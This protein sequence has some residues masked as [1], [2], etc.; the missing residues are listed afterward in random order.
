MVIK[1][2]G[3]RIKTL[4]EDK[5][6]SQQEMANILSITRSAYSNYENSLREVPL[7]VLSQIADFHQTSVDFL[8]GRTNDPTPY[9]PKEHSED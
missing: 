8:I 1:L 4:R 7:A 2:N 5:D 6:L 3:K 9:L